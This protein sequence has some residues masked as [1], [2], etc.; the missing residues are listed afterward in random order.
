MMDIFPMASLEGQSLEA[1]ARGT[2]VCQ[3]QW[4]L[5]N[6]RKSVV[7]LFEANAAEVQ[8]SL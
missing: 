1:R 3:S 6:A 2:K 7:S 4:V 8:L 5:Q